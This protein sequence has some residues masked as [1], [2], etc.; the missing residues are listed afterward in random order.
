[1]IFSDSS[2]LTVPQ[3]AVVDIIK[4]DYIYLN[5]VGTREYKVYSVFQSDYVRVSNIRKLHSVAAR[6]GN[7]GC[8]LVF[9]IALSW[10][11]RQAK[12]TVR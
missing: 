1:M 3:V 12:T 8:D 9:T 2:T 4:A 11:L 5:I 6:L 7:L 10:R